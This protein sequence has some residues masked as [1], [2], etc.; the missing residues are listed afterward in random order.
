MWAAIGLR[1]EDE[2]ILGSL[3][4]TSVERVTISYASPGRV[5][6]EAEAF[7]AAQ[8]NCEVLVGRG[9]SMLPLFPDRTV[10][11]VRRTPLSDLQVGMTVVFLGDRGRPVAH[12]LVSNSAGGWI[13]KGLANDEVDRTRVRRQNYIGQVVRAYLP[14][15]AAAPE[16]G[17][18]IAATGVIVAATIAQ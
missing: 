15:N 3:A 2:A 14:E 6:R 16:F 13:A 10:I 4:A 12:T 18:G 9:D 8:D 11:V 17:R 7:A 1:A 5:W